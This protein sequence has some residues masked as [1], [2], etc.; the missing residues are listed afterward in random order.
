MFWSCNKS[1]SSLKTHHMRHSSPRI[2]Q[3]RFIST[4]NRA[5]VLCDF[6]Y[7]HVDSWLGEVYLDLPKGGLQTRRARYPTRYFVALHLKLKVSSCNRIA[8]LTL[9][10]L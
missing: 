1:A 6:D 7:F 4:L 10:S 5:P 9:V 8:M 2:F 3:H